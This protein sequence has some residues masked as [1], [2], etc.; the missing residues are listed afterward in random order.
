MIVSGSAENKRIKHISAK[1]YLD[2]YYN[3]RSET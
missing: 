1:K 2:L 3:N